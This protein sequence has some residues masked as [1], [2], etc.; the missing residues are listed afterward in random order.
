MKDNNLDM[1]SEKEEENDRNIKGDDNNEDYVDP[2]EQFEQQEQ[3]DPPKNKEMSQGDVLEAKEEQKD[4]LNMRSEEDKEIQEEKGAVDDNDNF[5]DDFE[6]SNKY[7]V[8]EDSFDNVFD[9][10]DEVQNTKMEATG[11]TLGGFKGFKPPPGNK[12]FE[13][14]SSSESDDSFKIRDGNNQKN[15][16]PTFDNNNFE[17]DDEF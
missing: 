13:G 1:G 4:T 14:A 8:E 5:D 16:K 17:D 6:D 11:R 10:H 7:K 9:D 3:S 12:N 15:S 2:F